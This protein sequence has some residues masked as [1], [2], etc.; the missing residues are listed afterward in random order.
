MICHFGGLKL[1]ISGSFITHVSP[2]VPVTER[3]RRQLRQRGHGGTAWSRKCS[4]LTGAAEHQHDARA[5]TSPSCPVSKAITTSAHPHR[6]RPRG[7]GSEKCPCLSPSSSPV[8]RAL[9]LRQ[10]YLGKLQ[11]SVPFVWAALSGW[12]VALFFK[13]T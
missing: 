1:R 10:F 4:R 9:L 2:A 6:E 7:F 12:Q 3:E 13:C 5:P 11:L 8:P